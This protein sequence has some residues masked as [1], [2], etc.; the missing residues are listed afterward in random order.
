MLVWKWKMKNDSLSM[1]TVNNVTMQSLLHDVSILQ[2][3][4]NAHT[5]AKP[6]CVYTYIILFAFHS[7][8]LKKKIVTRELLI[9][10]NSAGYGAG[11]SLLFPCIYKC[12]V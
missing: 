8:M 3:V 12:S 4:Q 6:R 7:I 9:H 11:T 2:P 5:K 10:S 1:C